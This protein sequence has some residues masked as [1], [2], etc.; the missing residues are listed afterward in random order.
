MSFFYLDE[1]LKEA[2][3]YASREEKWD[4]L[5]SQEKAVRLM[6]QTVDGDTNLAAVQGPPGTGKTSVVEAFAKRSLAEFLSQKPGE[7]IIYIAPTNYLTFYAFKRISA[8]LLKSGHSLGSLLS[9]QRIYGSRIKPNSS[10]DQIRL[11]GDAIDS[12]LLSRLMSNV[13]DDVRLI[14]STEYQRISN[15]LGEMKP[16]KI[17][18]VADE[19]SKSPFFRLFLPLAERIAKN[20]EEYYP[21]SLLVLGD[22]Q[23]AI[24]VPGE[25][26]SLGV[27]LL[28]RHV[29]RIVQEN[30]K[31]RKNWVLLDTTFRLPTPSERPISMGYYDGR[32][33]GLH[34]ASERMSL[35]REVLLDSHSKIVRAMEDMGYPTRSPEF[36]KVTSAISEAVVSKSPI[37]A[38]QTRGF[39]GSDTYDKLRV[40]LTFDACSFMQIAACYVDNGFSVASIAPYSDVMDAVAFRYHRIGGKFSRPNMATVQSVLG[41]ESDV[42]VASLGKEWD[43][44]SRFAPGQEDM[45]TIYKREPEMLNVQLSRH[46]C[47]LIVVG[48]VAKLQELGDPRI[49]RTSQ[50]MLEMGNKGAILADLTKF[51]A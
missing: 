28:I 8:Q 42:V 7:V 25:F 31:L 51:S 46:R 22:P 17:H 35:I 21:Y 39:R 45:A 20:P 3:R 13:D 47:M 41:G 11:S 27:P 34:S 9:L 24:G 38:L 14:F 15:R 18:I 30:D 36:V 23:Q 4:L 26:K 19:A 29:E 37:V 10:K 32:V 6:K 40:R 16:K 33:K 50:A 43:M 49:E 2:T 1:G 48:N 12:N 5:E 44:G